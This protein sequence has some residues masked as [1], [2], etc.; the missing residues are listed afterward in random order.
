MT[1][2][3]LQEAGMA[4][5]EQ[6]VAVLDW[7]RNEMGSLNLKARAGCG[8]TTTL[9]EVAKEAKG[10]IIFLAYNKSIS[11][12][13]GAK[14][15]KAGIRNAKAQTLHAAGYGAWSRVAPGL[16]PEPKKVEMI[17]K[18]FSATKGDFCDKNLVAICKMVSLAKQAAFNVEEPTPDEHWTLI[19]EHYGVDEYGDDDRM[20]EIIKYARKALQKSVEMDMAMID[21]EDMIYAPLIHDVK[22]RQYDWILLDE[23]QDTN[24][25][26]RLLAVRMMKPRGR[27]IAVGDDRQAIYG[28]TGADSEAMNLI[29]KTLQ[30]AEL[31]LTVTYRCPKAIV[32]E[33][34]KLVDDIKAHET[35][36]EGTV[37][38]ISVKDQDGKP[39]FMTE[40][41]EAKDVIL[42]RNTKPLIDQ[43][44][45]FIRNHIGCRVEGR[46]IGEGLITLANHWKT[47]DTL[48]KLYDKLGDYK[49]REVKKWTNKGQ[50]TKAQAIADKVETLQVI[51]EELM[52][53][54]KSTIPD[55]VMF[56]RS[57][58]GDTK[59]GEAPN[60]ITLSTIHKSK[61][62]EWDRVY[63]LDRDGTLPSKYA[64]QDWQKV[65]EANLE[66]VAVTR[67]KKEL[68]DIVK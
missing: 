32:A 39:W 5:S 25:A 64:K 1:L 66:Y 54:G 24:K 36:P 4:L 29:K 26:R 13:I 63:L 21:F 53:Q 56:V 10:D 48:S 7:V 2:F 38:A 68:V 19:A 47:A 57:L 59:T 46:D 9:I 67:A 60:V 20:E 8:K 15:S 22:M 65:Q 30:S 14:L 3:S 42:C 28:F 34:N 12:E 37:R 41:S 40:K 51:I 31:P 27:L 23:A 17:V 44:H 43:A 55:L 49:A 33:A 6:Q 11:E 62:R 45:L 58:F 50:E 61:G 35:A 16:K 52:N 18:G